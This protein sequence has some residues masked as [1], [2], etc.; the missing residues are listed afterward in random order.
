M[1]D[2]LTTQTITELEKVRGKLFTNSEVRVNAKTAWFK[3]LLAW[4]S[5]REIQLGRGSDTHYFINDVGITAIDQWYDTHN[6]GSLT[7]INQLPSGDRIAMSRV[8]SNE[9]AAKELPTEHLVLIASTDLDLR[10][11]QQSLFGLPETPAQINQELDINNIDLSLFDYLIVVENRDC[12]N[13]WHNYQIQSCITRPLVVYR[14]HEQTH[15]KGCV[16]LKS[17]WLK[18]KGKVGQVYCGDFDIDGLAIAIN[19]NV[20]YQHLLLPTFEVLSGQLIPAHF[21]DNNAYHKR[22]LINRCPQQWQLL[23]NLLLTQQAGL[24]QQWMFDDELF[25]Y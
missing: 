19:S 15:S 12:F 25:L 5:E 8:S 22:D 11:S 23:L 16:E 9:K 7:Q 14:G 17:R 6:K 20:S 21:D 18:E 3:Q 24:R 4:C 13:A 10:L 1:D 2:L